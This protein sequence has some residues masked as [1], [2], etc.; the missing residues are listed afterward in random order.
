MTE[1]RASL[2][3]MSKTVNMSAT[4]EICRLSITM[5]YSCRR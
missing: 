4:N 5:S 3:F 1:G 2:Y